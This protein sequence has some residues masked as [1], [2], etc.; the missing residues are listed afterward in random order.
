[1]KLN[2]M[3]QAYKTNDEFRTHV[4]LELRQ[5]FGYYMIWMVIYIIYMILL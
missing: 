2:N 3:I 4:N 1:M 5:L